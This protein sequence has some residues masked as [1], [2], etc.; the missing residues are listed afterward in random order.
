VFKYKLAYYNQIELS[1]GKF[2]YDTM[3]GDNINT[4]RDPNASVF[5]KTLAVV[6]LGSNLIPGAG[7]LKAVGSF[8]V[9]ATV[10]VLKEPAKN[11]VKAATSWLKGL[12]NK[13]PSPPKGTAEGVVYKRTNVKT[14]DEYIGQSKSMVRYEK[15][16]AEHRRADKN[17]RYEF[18]LVGRANPGKELNILEQKK[19]NEHGGLKKKGGTLENK[20]NQISEK[21]WKQHGIEAF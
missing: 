19:I 11:A 7:Q 13:S 14:G 2:V 15:R 4:I 1:E 12:V 9:K 5:F 8:A 10:K 21:K 20:R 18:E 3:I 17:A 6:D 16:Q